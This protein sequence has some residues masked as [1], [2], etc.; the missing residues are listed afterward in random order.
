MVYNGTVYQHHFSRHTCGYHE[1]TFGPDTAKQTYWHLLKTKALI[2]TIISSTAPL[3][4][5]S[6][7]PFLPPYLHN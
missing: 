2:I 6:P 4:L 1:G 7:C 5:F 3:W